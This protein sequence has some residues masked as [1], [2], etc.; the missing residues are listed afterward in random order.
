MKSFAKFFNNSNE[1]EK[2]INENLYEI[3]F[4]LESF[5]KTEKK[6]IDYKI[7]FLLKYNLFLLKLGKTVILNKKQQLLFDYLKSR[8]FDYDKCIIDFSLV[9]RLIN[10]N[11]KNKIN[12]LV[13]IRNNFSISHAL[14]TNLEI[15]EY[16]DYINWFEIQINNLEKSKDNNYKDRI[17]NTKDIEKNLLFLHFITEI[18]ELDINKIKKDKYKNFTLYLKDYEFIEWICDWLIDNNDYIGSK[19]I[20][21]I[22]N[23]E[24]P[25]L[26]DNL[27]EKCILYEDKYISLI[28]IDKIYKLN[29]EFI[30]KKHL[31]K[32]TDIFNEWF[33][34]EEPF[35]EFSNVNSILKTDILYKYIFEHCIH[36]SENFIKEIYIWILKNG[37]KNGLIAFNIK[38]FERRIWDESEST[39][40][41]ILSLYENNKNLFD[42]RMKESIYTDICNDIEKV[43]WNEK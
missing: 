7:L 20:I 19:L 16:E 23:D 14:N 42:I 9:L 1:M 28:T 18:N 11:N 34:Q 8:N 4:F 31:E 43:V 27:F 2:Q 5:L 26:Y 21:D 40:R 13:K 38:I 10:P 35:Y 37:N 32:L 12:E 15:Q 29:N 30:K 39:K 22:L 3:E 33:I 24:D 6:L 36:K 17:N 25:W 41:L